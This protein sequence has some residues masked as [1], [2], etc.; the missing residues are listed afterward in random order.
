LSGVGASCWG[1]GERRWRAPVSVGGSGATGGRHRRHR[2]ERAR[3]CG[4]VSWRRPRLGNTAKGR[5]AALESGTLCSLCDFIREAY[6]TP[7][8]PAARRSMWGRRA[9][10]ASSPLGPSPPIPSRAGRRR[11]SK[12]AASVQSRTWQ[13]ELRTFLE[14]DMCC[15]ST[16]VLDLGGFEP[17]DGELSSPQMAFDIRLEEH[18]LRVVVRRV[19]LLLQVD[20][21]IGETLNLLR[22]VPEQ[23]LLAARFARPT[24]GQR[25]VGQTPSARLS[26][27]S[28]D[29][30][31]RAALCQTV[32]QGVVD[33]TH[34]T[35]EVGLQRSPTTGGELLRGGS[36]EIRGLQGASP[37]RRTA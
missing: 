22:E 28:P 31:V 27:R 10:L 13:G 23:T 29:Q 11:I 34:R 4:A 32:K 14:Q 18:L 21:E 6:S 12:T 8:G 36:Q 15:E 24:V 33:R 5:R 30:T 9:S 3:G 35:A 19:A 20:E 1:V 37:P 16:S 26:S 7:P 25:S 17:L 2:A